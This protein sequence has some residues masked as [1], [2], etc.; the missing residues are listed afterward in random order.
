MSLSSKESFPS[1]KPAEIIELGIFAACLC[2][3]SR[4]RWPNLNFTPAMDLLMPPIPS[5]GVTDPVAQFR[6]RVQ[7]AV[8]SQ[9]PAEIIELGIFAACLCILSRR[10]WPNLNFTPAMDLLMPPIPSLG[11]T[12]PAAQFRLRV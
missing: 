3:L 4:R 12:D 1:Q 10:R 7:G 8:A 5:L 11:V 6:L 9:K 2:I